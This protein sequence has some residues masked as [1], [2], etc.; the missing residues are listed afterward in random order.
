M[1]AKIAQ[2]R[3]ERGLTQEQLSEQMG[4]LPQYLQR[5]EAGRENLTL[6]SLA[7]IAGLL[8][9]DPSELVAPSSAQK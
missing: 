6:R 9:V 7:K 3:R 1:G 2:L 4:V 8:G 5:I